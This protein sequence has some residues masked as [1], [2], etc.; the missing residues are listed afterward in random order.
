MSCTRTARWST[1]ASVVGST[2]LMRYR[3]APYSIAGFEVALAN[4]AEN[5]EAAAAGHVDVGDD[6]VEGIRLE[7]AEGGASVPRLFREEA[8]ALQADREDIEDA[9]LV[10][11]DQGFGG[12]VAE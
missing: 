3:N 5:I 2:G 1:S 10:V 6:G 12:T 7:P 9:G 11:H 4:A 8:E